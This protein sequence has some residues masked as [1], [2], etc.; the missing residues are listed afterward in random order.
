MDIVINS[1]QSLEAAKRQLEIQFHSQRFL[2]VKI[3]SGKQRTLTQNAALHKFCE[4]LGSALNDAGLY[5]MKVLKQ[6][7]ELPWSQHTV[8]ENI[9]KP[10]QKAVL[11][12]DSTTEAE[13]KEYGMIYDIVNRHMINKFGVHVPWPEKDKNSYNQLR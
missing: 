2:T 13:R 3:S 8:K 10:V 4:L 5:Q 6:C 9:W 11:R 12:K 1:A 7:A